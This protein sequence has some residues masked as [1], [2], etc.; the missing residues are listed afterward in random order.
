[1]E[2]GDFGEAGGNDDG[3]GGGRGDTGEG[4]GKGDAEEEGKEDTGDGGASI[5]L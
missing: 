3:E 1:V 2:V 4:E 5:A